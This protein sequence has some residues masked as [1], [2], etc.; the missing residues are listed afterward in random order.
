MELTS[1]GYRTDLMML[2][3]QGGEIHDRG[4]HLVVR[5]PAQP[6]FHWGNFLL[7][8]DPPTAADTDRWQALFKAEFPDAGHMTF[9]LDTTDGTTGDLSGFVET[10]ITAELSVVL[11]ANDVHPPPRPNTEARLRMLASDYDWAQTVELRMA[12][13][14]TDDEPGHRLFVERKNAAMRALQEAGRGGWFGAFADGRMVGGLGVYT[15]GSGV[16]RYQS[17]ETHPDYRNRGLA[18]TLVHHAGRYALTDL[19]AETL[20]I[21]ADPD[22]VASRI[23]RSVG[24]DG[25]E[26]QIQLSR[27]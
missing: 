25:T 27:A 18:G 10:G 15:D 19:D 14:D 2:A 24:F 4:D 13:D 3:M 5:T 16:A 1:L 8:A 12:I 6:T 20:V 9:G 21:V 23:Y 22:Y 7:F 17:V 26:T 11:T